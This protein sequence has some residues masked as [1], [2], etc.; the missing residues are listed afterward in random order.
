MMKQPAPMRL[1]FLCLVLSACAPGDGAASRA[2]ARMAQ[3][4]L[5]TTD[6]RPVRL[7]RDIHPEEDTTFGS[8]P[9][10]FARMGSFVYFSAADAQLERI[11]LWRTDGTDEG[12]TRVASVY[13]PETPT[14]VDGLLY[15]SSGNPDKEPWRSDGTPEG[16]FRLADLQPGTDGSSPKGFTGL[17]GAV[18][19]FTE[20]GTPA[21]WR[22]DPATGVTTALRSVCESY[23]SMSNLVVHAGRLYFTIEGDRSGS[24]L[25]TSDGTEAGTVRVSEV[26]PV[27]FRP[28]EPGLVSLDGALYFLARESYASGQSLWRSDGTTAGTRPVLRLD[29]AGTT[30]RS[31]SLLRVDDA[32]AIA[33]EESSTQW[34]L[35]WSDGTAP[36][37]VRLKEFTLS[38]SND[39]LVSLTAVGNRLFFVVADMGSYPSFDELWSSDGTASGTVRVK[40]YKSTTSSWD[41]AVRELTAVDDMLYFVAEDPTVG[42]ELWR[43]DGTE[44]GTVLV[45]NIDPRDAPGTSPSSGPR[46]LSAIGDTLYFTA[47]DGHS[48]YELWKSQGQAWNTVRVKDIYR[49]WWKA[50]GTNPSILGTAGGLWFFHA[51]ELLGGATTIF[52]HSLW[53]TD[54]TEAGTFAVKSL[55]SDWI[56]PPSTEGA[57][58]GSDFIFFSTDGSTGALWKTAGAATGDVVQL[59]TGSYPGALEAA[60]GQVFFY[61]TQSGLGEEL[62]RTDGTPE[63]TRLV[64]DLVPGWNS[65]V[66]RSFTPVGEW[67]YFTAQ[68]GVSGREVWRTDGTPE[69][70]SRV[71]DLMPGSGSSNPSGLTDVGGALFFVATTDVGL[72]LWRVGGPQEAP[73]LVA[74][75]AP[76][77]PGTVAPTRFTAAAGRLFFVATDPEHGAELWTSDGTSGGTHRVGDIWPGTG[78]S[79]PKELVAVGGLLFFTAEDGVSGRELWRSDGTEEGTFRLADIHPGSGS[80]FIDDNSQFI[81]GSRL[82]GLESEGLLLFAASAP[83]SGNESWLSDGTREGTRR[84][85]DL[86]PG[87]LGSMP[88]S[89]VRLGDR[90]A[91]AADDG[92]TGRE[93]WLLEVAALTNREPPTLTCPEDLVVEALQPAGAPV[94]FPALET[95]DDVTASPSVTFSRTSGG[96]FPLGTS[97]VT[98]TASDDA[99]NRASCSFHVTVRDHTPPAVFCPGD[100]TVEGTEAAGAHVDFRSPTA[101]DGR[102]APPHVTLSAAPGSLFGFGSHTV[103][104]TATDAAGNTSSCSFV[105]TVSDTQVPSLACPDD[106]A[107]EATSPEGARVDFPP[108]TASDGVRPTPTLTS[109]PASG[110]TLANGVHRVTITATDL[111]GLSSTCSFRVS[112]RDTT[113]PQVT[114]P[115]DVQVEATS[116]QGTPVSFPAP[117]AVDTVSTATLEVSHASG[118]LYPRGTTRV[119]V[120]SRDEAGNTA[121][122]RFTV[123]VRDTTAPQVTC[124]EPVEVRATAGWGAQVTF[125]DAVARDGIT[126]APTVVADPPSGGVFAVGE[127]SVTFTAR[128]EAGNTATCSLPVRVLPG[129]AVTEPGGCSTVPVGSGLAWSAL[130]LLA[131]LAMRRRPAR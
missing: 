92:Y 124:P 117:T 39:G 109:Q 29:P 80:S 106:L 82:L 121:V 72:G 105:V 44:Q 107:V 58:L 54:G 90:V 127:H 32:L 103:T 98:A 60:G 28:S 91:F 52:T 77:G 41:A 97:E 85:V 89:F 110:S 46:F 123:T 10:G 13:V 129:V 15:F 68:D 12:T 16:T 30:S 50:G 66:P 67:L 27:D 43:T 131:W 8:R 115:E 42:V 114:C 22:Y 63:G 45:R 2:P 99:G 75:L 33:V 18:Y 73:A 9:S 76:P 19:F 118:A 55:G 65:S 93:P 122:C 101:T 78:G 88:R 61:G 71:A 59:W 6:T 49:E 7:I 31:M 3:A 11:G 35:W 1:A 126:P 116:A 120:S 94:F 83:D 119:S 51:R 69:G 81:Q 95:H 40:Q 70:T 5:T 96:F 62:W 56:D 4:T 20:Y 64:K 113:A 86:F 17:A 34:S 100:V 102:M 21:L 74:V 26:Q 37:T 108:A 128:D 23:C 130:A 57:S 38:Y 14:E 104:A 53:R 48:G 84:L 47:D 125:P 79:Q 36:G 112:V 87:A 24:G 111:A 25:W